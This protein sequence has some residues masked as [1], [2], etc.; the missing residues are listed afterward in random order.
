MQRTKK[1][2]AGIFV[3]HNHHY[4]FGFV[5]PAYDGRVLR[6]RGLPGSNP[7]TKFNRKF[8]FIAS[9]LRR[10]RLFF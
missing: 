10:L 9:I 7:T 3:E 5:D 1:K 2:Q 6:G 8:R 4:T